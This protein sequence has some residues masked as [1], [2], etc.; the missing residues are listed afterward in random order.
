M[1]L[2]GTLKNILYIIVFIILLPLIP[3]ATHAIQ[4]FF[5]QFDQRTSVGVL[6]IK[7][8]LTDSSYCVRHLT[9]FFNDTSIKAIL[10]KIECPGSTAGT[11]QAIFTEILN[12]K[13]EHPKPVIVLVENTCTSGA[14]YIACACDHIIATP[15]A[16]IGSIGV[17]FSSLFQVKSFLENYKVGY[18][19]LA[20]GVNKNAG[21]PLVDQ[22]SENIAML[23]SLLDD[24]Y[25]QFTQDVAHARKLP[26]ATASQWANGKVFTGRQAHKLGLIDELGTASNA[27]KAIKEKALI[28]K[29]IKWV[30]APKPSKLA[31]LLGT[32]DTDEN[33]DMVSSVVNSV[34]CALETRY[35]KQIMHT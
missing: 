10:L 16:L 7:G 20:A 13:K 23:Q 6:P 17:A 33:S 28:E 18:L 14:Y 26:I 8:L 19:P 9:E 12:L 24:S 22:S 30:H 31:K 15:S 21:N 5:G 2:S 4:R 1:T 3:F 11:G 25:E 35:G 27:I 29:D 32:D 34:C